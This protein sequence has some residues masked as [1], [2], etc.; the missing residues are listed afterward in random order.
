MNVSSVS[1]RR[2]VSADTSGEVMLRHDPLGSPEGCNN[3]RFSGRKEVEIRGPR[4]IGGVRSVNATGPKAT[5]QSKVVSGPEGKDT[6]RI[7]EVAQMRSRLMS[8]P[9]VRMDKV[10]EVRQAIENGSYETEAKIDATIDKL[11]GS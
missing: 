6:A 2:S 10:A 4:Y 5:H 3:P 11:L 7:S 1:A 9:D 8:A